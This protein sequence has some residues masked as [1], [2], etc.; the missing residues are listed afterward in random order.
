MIFET[1]TLRNFGLY[2]GEQVLDL[3]PRQSN[4]RKKPIILFGGINGG[5]KT[6]LLDAIQLALYGSRGTYSKRTNI[7]YDKFL[8]DSIN[9]SVKP[10]EGASVGLTMRISSE[11][12]EHVCEIRRAWSQR[13]RTLR[14]RVHVSK[15][16]VPDQFLAEHWVDFVEE[17]IPLGISQLFFFD[18]EKIRFLADDETADDSLGSAIKALLGLDLAERLITDASVL[19]GRLTAEVATDPKHSENTELKKSLDDIEDAL[20]VKKAERASLEND[21]LRAENAMNHANDTFAAVG[22]T[23]W[24]KR[25]SH[26]QKLVQLQGRETELAADLVKLAASSLPLCLVDDLLNRV[27]AQDASEVACRDQK[28]L[29]KLLSTRDRQI[30]TALKKQSVDAQAIE[31]VRKTQKAD[32]DVRRKTHNGD[33]RLTIS[34]PAHAQLLYLQTEGL[35]QQFEGTEKLLTEL[36]KTQRRIE[37]TQRTVRTIPE[38]SDIAQVLQDLQEF[39]KEFAVLEDRAKRLDAEVASLQVKRDDIVSKLQKLRRE[40]IE[41]DIQN[42]EAGRM[43]KLA[44]RTQ[45]TMREFLQ[46]ATADK[47]DNLSKRISES[48]RFLLRKKTL[49]HHIYIDPTSF[50][51]TLYD[52]TGQPVPKHRLSEGE[53]QVFAIAVLWGLAQASPRPLPSIIDTP[54]ARLDSEHRQHLVDRYFPNAS[55][56]VIILSTDTEVDQRFYKGLHS[57]ISR[58]YHLDY[59]EADKTTVATEG[60]FWRT[61]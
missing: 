50:S 35:Q 43:A 44:V 41:S 40:I 14:E 46:R 36:E 58:A 7:P 54:M 47:I 49:V 61:K 16:G 22:G 29:Q 48:F 33:A 39:T 4:G 32:R 20:R 13:G 42:E 10:S 26:R 5:G 1:L 25:E 56:Q 24:E 53:K 52:D 8:R 60:Y 18:A 30:L 31:A 3:A 21:R 57:H 2:R 34:E 37:S 9:N 38:K 45:E 27:Q 11:G 51:I 23:H 55:H 19:E 15:D 6:T 17:V 59:D 28:V 12:C